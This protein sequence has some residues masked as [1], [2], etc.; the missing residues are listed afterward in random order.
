MERGTSLGLTAIP[1]KRKR[2]EER[3][4]RMDNHGDLALPFPAWHG[5]WNM[6]MSMYVNDKS[7]L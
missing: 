6:N 3:K 5:R 2:E 4:A 1:H 7:D